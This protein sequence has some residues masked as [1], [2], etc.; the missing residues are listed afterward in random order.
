MTV[1]HDPRPRAHFLKGAT[2]PPSWALVALSPDSAGGR[3]GPGGYFEH[4]S[5]CEFCSAELHM[6]ERHRPGFTAPAEAPPPPLA[7]YLL[8]AKLP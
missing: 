7:V 6:L 2:C 4:L 8:A 1:S 5:A 3:A